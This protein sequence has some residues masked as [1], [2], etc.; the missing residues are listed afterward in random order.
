MAIREQCGHPELGLLC[1][2]VAGRL[3]AEIKRMLRA[4]LIGLPV[5]FALLIVA[6]HAGAD[7]D[8][9][10]HI[11]GG[12]CVSDEQQN[13][14]PKPCAQVDL[15]GGYAVLKDSDG[16]T[17]FL[18]IP[19]ARVSGIESP[20]ILAPN[21]PNYWDAAWQARRFVEDNAHRQ[22]PRDAIGLAINASDARSQDQLHI[23]VD[24]LRPDVRAALHEHADAIGANWERFPVPLAGH[25]Y[26]AMR[27]TQEELGKT[28]PFMLLADGI[29]GARADM[30]HYTLVVAGD[31]DGF[32]LL[33][34]RARGHG[35][36]LED[37]DC[38]LA[39]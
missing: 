2:C 28:D 3:R 36:D 38:A 21:A 30:A 19:T 5:L 10:W 32:V 37:H 1:C 20:D 17:Q 15:T 25:D 11:V 18:L 34:E 23:H 16:A 33:A 35:E 26:M 31:P 12:Q 13:H 9:L 8:T 29:Q 39:Q 4:R 6:R 22:L 24:C 27:L 7:A 14:S